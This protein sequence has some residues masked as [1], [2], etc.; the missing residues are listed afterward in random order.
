MSDTPLHFV[1]NHL[2]RFADAQVVKDL[3][4]GELLARFREG[5]E[6]AAFAILMQRHGPMVMSVSQ[7]VLR[8]WH[9][10]E[11]VFQATFLV[12]ARRAD[13]IRKV[14]SLGSW[15]HGVAFRIATKA[16]R[17]FARGRRRENRIIRRADTEPVDALLRQEIQQV[18]DEL[19]ADLPEKYKLPLVLHYFEG[20]SHAEA[21]AQLGWR[22]T[23][24]TSR[25]EKARELLRGRLCRRGFMLSTA[26]LG[27]ELMRNM[28]PGA[29]SAQLVL[30]TVKGISCL[31]AE[32]SGPVAAGA[33]VLAE[34]ILRS[35][36][37]SKALKIAFAFVLVSCLAVLGV[38]FASQTREATTAGAWQVAEAVPD[39]VPRLDADG[40]PLPAEAIYRL[41]SRRF[42]VEGACGFALP[43]PDGKHILVQPQP[44]LSGYPAQELVL[45][46]AETG[47][48]V[49]A[50]EDS[51]RVPKFHGAAAVRPASFSP[52]G[53]TL[54]A[55]VKDKN[56]PAQRAEQ[57]SD[58]GEDNIPCKRA[59]LVWDVTTGKLKAEWPLPAGN[60]YG[61]SMLGVYVAPDGKSLYVYGSIRMHVNTNRTIGGEPGIHVLDAAS[62]KK[63]QTWDGAGF[64]VGMTAANELI[65]FREN[66]AIAAYDS[67]TG[68]LT[69]SFPVAGFV[70]SVILSADRKN[71]LAVANSNEAGKQ[72]CAI[73]IWDAAT[74]RE[75]RRL[76][77]KSGTVGSWARLSFS[78]GKTI[79]L[80]TGSGS[81]LRWDLA[82]GHELP[83]RHAHKS[84]I[85]ELFLRP[86]KNELIS[87]GK[88][89]GAIRRWDSGT[90]EALSSTNAY[91]GI[92]EMT[93][94]QAP[95]G[96]T[97]AVADATGRLEIWDTSTG[98]SARTFRLPSS[99]AH[100]LAFSPDGKSLLDAAG[101]G[102]ITERNAVTGRPIRELPG[103][104]GRGQGSS[105]ITFSHDGRN[106]LLM[107]SG[108]GGSLIRWPDCTDIWRSA[109]ECTAAFSPDGQRMVCGNWNQKTFFRNAATGAVLSELPGDSLTSAAFSP[110][111]GF[112]AT[113][114]LYGHW[115]VRNGKTGAV[116]KEKTG[117]KYVWDVTFSPSGWLLAVAGDNSV[118]VYD[119]ASWQELVRF[120]G[121]EGTVKRTF[122]GSNEATL[123]SA[124]PED[125]TALVWS[126][127]SSNADR[128]PDPAK[129]WSDLCG[130]GPAIRRGVW[131]AAQYPDIAI[132][133]FREKWPPAKQPI[134]LE[135]IRR[136]ITDLDD[137]RFSQRESA[138]TQLQKV[139]RAAQDELQ[140]ELARGPSPEAKQRIESI[141][142][143]L[144][145]PVTAEHSTDDARELRAV[146][147]L[148][149]SG[150]AAAERLLSE[151]A[152][153]G[154]GK[155]L[156]AEAEHS[157]ARL[158]KRANP[159]G[160]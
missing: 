43:T 82:D 37:Y 19:I 63:L 3:T 160:S 100:T 109:D 1:L 47:L 30:D 28:A 55:L 45:V 110:D 141:L 24:F 93:I 51:R 90:G 152:E 107:R 108:V 65:T 91:V 73:Q 111:G 13:S 46:D 121:H 61:A 27:S 144:A 136:L 115:F 135:H 2:R 88:W 84:T 4:D 15:L 138:T 122:F 123:L 14:V 69:R 96:Q 36:C 139:G 112:L 70:P 102:S 56:E 132:R 50:F 128:P 156:W 154:T 148:E 35:M 64:P 42:R 76:M 133:L 25:L 12:L 157:L 124:S 18:F 119:T 142:T 21:A 48:R 151:W 7:R 120:G 38:G 20:L 58:W 130:D 86:G 67:K 105:E 41:G 81:I 103:L 118:A 101:S 149:L 60:L 95:D 72:I 40:R 77:A 99:G 153:A 145:L 97:V 49:R 22:K 155:L 147:A 125:G 106:L 87:V 134:D 137:R 140:K 146:W 34:A 158:R 23:S 26:V 33:S 53:R 79:C 131:A 89:D 11:D 83:A 92:D 113:G 8:D 143:R 126:I 150:T 39:T 85:G 129:L 78:D 104:E 75:I 127:R 17:R 44:R 68:K 116:L 159:K 62:G 5:K 54:Y 16:I 66:A 10:A 114:H 80:G 9:G 94:A 29:V 52:D 117:F 98:R 57:A 32:G 71:V 59:V 74:G 6:E 31:H